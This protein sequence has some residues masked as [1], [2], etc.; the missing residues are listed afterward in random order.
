[1]GLEEIIR[2]LSENY[3][4]KYDI[5]SVENSQ[6]AAIKHKL[7]HQNLSIQFWKVKTKGLL[8]SGLPLSEVR[9]FPFPIVIFNFIE[10]DLS[11]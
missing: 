7:T 1:V 4:E 11:Q 3:S 2:L 10:Q 6:S 5:V 8:T 9:K